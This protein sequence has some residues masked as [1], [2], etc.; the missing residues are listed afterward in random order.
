MNKPKVVDTV[1]VLHVPTQEIKTVTPAVAEYMCSDVVDAS[2]KVI[3]KSEY[4]TVDS[5]SSN[6]DTK[7]LAKAN[8][9][10]E[11]LQGLVDELTAEVDTLK[12]KIVEWEEYAAKVEADT[13]KAATKK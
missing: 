11:H 8:K 9:T 7:G 2:G 6:V 5:D 1:K 12:A 4:K 10:I 3:Q 13:T